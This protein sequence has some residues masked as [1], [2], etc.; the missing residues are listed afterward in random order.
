MVSVVLG[1]LAYLAVCMTS[2]CGYSLHRKADLPFTEIRIGKIE[3]Y[4]V[5]PKL[6]DK[7]HKALVREFTRN[8]ITVDPSAGNVLS[9]VVRRFE[10][11]S[12]SEKKDITVEYRIVIDADFTYRDSNGKMRE[13]KKV[14]PPFIVSSSGAGD[15]AVLLGSRDMAEDKAVADIAVGL[16]GALIY[17]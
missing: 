3:N 16:I 1:L 9:G 14:M 4:S 15:M 2:G 5:E 13:I 17:Q 8:G 12:L 10:M 11:S 6:Q 7:L